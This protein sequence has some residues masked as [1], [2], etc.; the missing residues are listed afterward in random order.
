[1][2]SEDG[3]VIQTLS[4]G[5]EITIETPA[6][7][8]IQG[9]RSNYAKTNY[10]YIRIGDIRKPTSS[11]AGGMSAEVQALQD[12]QHQ[13]DQ[14]MEEA[15]GPINLEIGPW[16]IKGVVQIVQPTERGVGGG[17]PKADFCLVDYDGNYVGFISHKD[18]GGAKAFQQYG[19]ISKQ[20]GLEHR[21]IDQFVRDLHKYVEQYGVH[22]GLAVYRP[23]ESKALINEAVY[24]PMYQ[25]GRFSIENCHCIGQGDPIFRDG[26][27]TFELDFT[28]AFHLNGDVS[29]ARRGGYEAV[30]LA[31]KRAG[32][33]VKTAYGEEVRDVRAGIYPIAVA[34]GRRELTQI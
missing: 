10:G 14:A 33:R 25:S 19:G 27:D 5:D 21:E 6:I 29:W 17:D 15:D 8:S 16:T 34:Q 7:Q 11:R 12:F 32:R 18:A 31:T 28:D 30:F 1:M 22:K 23:V 24:G 20:S 9:H 2:Y 26:G 4:A 3:H 13:I